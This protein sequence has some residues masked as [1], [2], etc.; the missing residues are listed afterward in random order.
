MELTWG[1]VTRLYTRHLYALIN[2]VLFLNRLVAFMDEVR[3]ELLFW[4]QLPRHHIDSDIWPSLKGV[5]IRMATDASD[6]AWGGYSMTGP[7]EIAR[8]YFSEQETV[9]FSTYRELL[10]VSRWL[11]AMAH[12]YEGRFMVL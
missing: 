3:G 12:R 7:M 6:F 1:P 9:Q 10:S 2:S 11:Q 5:S 8:E 4:Q